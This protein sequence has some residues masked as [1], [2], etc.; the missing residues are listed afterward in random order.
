[1]LVVADSSLVR[2]FYQGE[3]VT[4]HLRA[5]RLWEHVWKAEP[6]PPQLEQFLASSDGSQLISAWRTC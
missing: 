2:I 3:E 1:V 5:K 6:A 4:L